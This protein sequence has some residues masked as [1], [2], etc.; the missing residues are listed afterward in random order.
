LIQPLE[1]QN[2]EICKNT[3]NYC[4]FLNNKYQPS[5]C[6]NLSKV[7]DFGLEIEFDDNIIN[8]LKNDDDILKFII[9]FR[10]YNVLRIV[11]GMAGLC[12]N[13]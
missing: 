1:H 11:S 8:T 13:S 10:F 6:A 7:D 4:F 3:G 2:S 12:F 9:Y 5:G